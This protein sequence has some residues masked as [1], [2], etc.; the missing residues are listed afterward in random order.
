MEIQ[1]DLFNSP[2][3]QTVPMLSTSCMLNIF[4]NFEVIIMY[5][6]T[7]IIQP[8]M[9]ICSCIQNFPISKY[10]FIFHKLFRSQNNHKYTYA[11]SFIA[12][13]LEIYLVG[14]IHLFSLREVKG[15][16]VTFKSII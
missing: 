1:I 2:S 16:K 9:S 10:L 12:S 6:Y 13:H 8:H 4:I 7:Q 3:T 11:S 14:R 15:N 5:I